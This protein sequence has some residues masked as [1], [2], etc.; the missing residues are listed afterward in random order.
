LHR[1]LTPPKWVEAAAATVVVAE[2]GLTSA[3]AAAVAEGLTLAEA[4]AVAEGLTLAEAAVV[5][6]TAAAISVATA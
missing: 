4:A 6:T 3:E 2:E 1:R 5:E